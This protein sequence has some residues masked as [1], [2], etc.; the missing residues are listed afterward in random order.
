MSI[1]AASTSDETKSDKEEIAAG[2][3]NLA[4]VCANVQQKATSKVLLASNCHFVVLVFGYL[5]LL[6]VFGCGFHCPLT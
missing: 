5:G 1:E 4:I 6:Q 3:M 2:M